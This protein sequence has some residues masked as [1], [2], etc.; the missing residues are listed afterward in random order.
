VSYRMTN[1]VQATKFPD[2]SVVSGKE[3]KG[4][5]GTAIKSVAMCLASHHNGK[6]GQCNPSLDTIVAETHLGRTTVIRVNDWLESIGFCQI[7]QTKGGG[8]FY[9]LREVEGEQG[10]ERFVGWG[11][12]APAPREPVSPGNRS[13]KGT[14]LLGNLAQFPEG[15]NQFHQETG[16]VSLGN[17]NQ[18]DNRETKRELQPVTAEAEKRLL[19]QQYVL[20]SVDEENKPVHY[21]DTSTLVLPFPG[22]EDAVLSAVLGEPRICGD[23][24]FEFSQ[25]CEA[26]IPLPRRR[27][28]LVY[29]IEVIHDPVHGDTKNLTLRRP[30]T[31]DSWLQ[32]MLCRILLPAGTRKQELSPVEYE[33]IRRSTFSSYGLDDDLDSSPIEDVVEG[34]L[35]EFPEGMSRGQAYDLAC[36][37]SAELRARVWSVAEDGTINQLP[38]CPPWDLRAQVFGENPDATKLVEAMSTRYLHYWDEDVA[39]FLRGGLSERSRKWLAKGGQQGGGSR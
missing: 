6:T 32:D 34:I 16:V 25:C 36:A 31:W 38:P 24:L 10:K 9:I 5:S 12:V 14:R 39:D 13:P 2:G 4:V 22:C 29:M 3:V 27:P 23:A 28:R 7:I 18:E 26:F 11:D 21:W 33:A 1:A 35:G 17:P 30:V 20:L 8:N 19:S 15:G 37:K